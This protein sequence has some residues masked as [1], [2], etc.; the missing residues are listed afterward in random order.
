MTLRDSNLDKLDERVF[1][2]LVIG[3]GINGA[4]S[5]SALTAQGAKVALIDRRRSASG[6]QG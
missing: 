5:A 1:D 2:V 4:V 6:D 3:G